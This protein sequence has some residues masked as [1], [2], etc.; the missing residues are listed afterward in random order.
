[1]SIQPAWNLDTTSTSTIQVAKG[2]L[3][4]ATTDNV[5]PLCIMACEQF[6]NTLAISPHTLRK[7]EHSVLPTPQSAVLAFL[8]GSVGYSKNDCVSYLGKSQ[9]GVQF[10]ALASTLITSTDKFEAATSLHAMLVGTASDKTLVPTVRQVK[11]LLNS[12]EPR[13]HHSG[14][15]DEVIGWHLLLARH[16][17]LQGYLIENEPCIPNGQG[18]ANMVDALRQLSR[19]GAADVTK[20]S[21]RTWESAAWTIAFIKWSLGY[22]PTITIGKANMSLLESPDSRATVNICEGGKDHQDFSVTIYSSIRGPSELVTEDWDVPA[23]GLISLENYGQLLLDKCCS[24]PYIEKQALEEAI[25]YSLDKMMRSISDRHF[26][27]QY[28]GAYSS[29]ASQ[30]HDQLLGRQMALKNVPSA[31]RPVKWQRVSPFRSRG[32][33]AAIYRHLFQEELCFSSAEDETDIC[34]L[35]QVA[36]TIGDCC[37]SK[38][39]VV[40]GSL[41]Q[42]GCKKECFF[43]TLLQITIDVL[44][45][46]L[47]DCPGLLQVSSQ[48]VSRTP[49]SSFLY[50]NGY[51]GDIWPDLTDLEYFDLL[52]RALQ[53]TGHD[54]GEDW[55]MSS[56]KGQAVWLS[57]YESQ[58]CCRGGY[59]SLSWHP[60]LISHDGDYFDG[61][62]D[63]YK[64]RGFRTSVVTPSPPHTRVRRPCNLFQN[65]K[66]EWDVFKTEGSLRVRLSVRDGPKTYHLSHMNRRL[67]DV[68]WDTV[69]VEHCGHA[70][71]TELV[72]S[73]PGIK[74]T[75]PVDAEPPDTEVNAVPVDGDDGLR[76]LA[77]LSLKS[78]GVWRVVFRDGACLNCCLEVCKDVGSSMM[79]L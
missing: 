53:L 45:L 78:A 30:R 79:I 16:P 48:A 19:I 5:Q 51:E 27:E 32:A 8:K 39:G 37:C 70:P 43:D 67:L 29:A 31:L 52:N 62:K 47:Y 60:G 13:C 44:A 35:P 18:L 63:D 55:I 34:S 10:L 28:N 26:P 71:T 12:I 68:F 69:L 72:T 2:I 17:A 76:F 75:W 40:G 61:V 57:I 41:V 14:F 50:Y 23:V 11:D 4:A 74:I 77:L 3:H 1:M 33:V 7:I 49:A 42:D 59:L 6:G 66:L 64:P 15:T 58:L 54:A 25:P 22:P 21:V 56:F 20:L 9:A 38:C 46:S 24:R 65:L 73:H 36:F